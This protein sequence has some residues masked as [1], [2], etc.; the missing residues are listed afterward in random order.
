[1]QLFLLALGLSADVVRFLSTWFAPAASIRAEN[2]FL[3]KQ[4]A[5]FLERG[6]KPRRASDREKVT[7]VLLARLFDW[8][9]A[10]VIVTPRTFLGWKQAIDRARWRWLS[11][12]KGRPP[13]PRPMRE[14]IRRI[15]RENPQWSCGQIARVVAVQLGLCGVISR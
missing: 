5:M 3:R 9:D 4:L 2:A 6:V 12:P 7:L 1:M 10:L 15:A 8:R 11:R 13:L 14:V